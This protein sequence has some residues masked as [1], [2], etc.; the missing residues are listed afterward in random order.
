MYRTSKFQPVCRCVI[1]LDCFWALGACF[2][3]LLAAAVMPWGGWRLLLALSSL[4]ALAFV[5][6]TAAWVPESARFSATRGETDLALETLERVAAENGQPMM[7]GRLTVDEDLGH[8]SRGRLGDLLGPGLRRTTLS[9]WF[10]WT[11]CSFIYYGVLLMTTE[12]F[13]SP[14]DHICARDGSLWETWYEG[15]HI[16]TLYSRQ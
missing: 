1:L 7:L 8:V 3:V 11:A 14:G 13:E 10:I 6:A 15:G 4:P 2:E 16:S 12:L 5:G 9:L